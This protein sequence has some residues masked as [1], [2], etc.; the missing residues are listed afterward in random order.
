MVS[1]ISIANNDGQLVCRGA[2]RLKDRN[3]HFKAAEGGRFEPLIRNVREVE[4]AALDRR[5]PRMKP[6]DVF[7]GP[8]N[9]LELRDG[10]VRVLD[11][12]LGCGDGIPQGLVLGSGKLFLVLGHIFSLFFSCFVFYRREYTV[13]WHTMQGL[14]CDPRSLLLRRLARLGRATLGADLGLRCAEVR[15]GHIGQEE[16]VAVA[17]PRDLVMELCQA[18]RLKLIKGRVEPREAFG[19]PRFHVGLA[20]RGLALEGSQLLEGLGGL[21]VKLEE[22]G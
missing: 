2:E 16:H 22:F 4:T 18:R 11:E 21:G 7:R 13:P 12:A 14:C 19:A 5:D 9:M 3:R 17:D 10:L 8:E 20:P 1:A 15:A 6:G